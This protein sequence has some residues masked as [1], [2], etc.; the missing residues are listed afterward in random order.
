[1]LARGR[2]GGSFFGLC[3]KNEPPLP[4]FAREASYGLN[5]YQSYKP[6]RT[7]KVLKL[8]IKDIAAS[9]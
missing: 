6:K 3:P 8:G 2:R 1:M 5:N 9:P 7:S 4:F